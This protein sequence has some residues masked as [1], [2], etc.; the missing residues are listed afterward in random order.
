MMNDA[1][2]AAAGIELAAAG[3]AVLKETLR[4]N[5]IL[6]ANQEALVQVSPRFPGVI[7]EM[8]KRVGEQVESGETLA[9]VESN[10]SLTSYELKAPIAGTVIERQAALGEYVSEQ[11]P[12]FV[13]ADLTSVW[14]DFAITRRDLKRVKIGDTVVIDPEDGSGHIEGKISYI[15]P[16]GASDTQSALARAVVANDGKLLPGLFVTGNVVMAEKSVP[17]AIKLSAL[18][19][20][21]GRT[22]I[23]V[24]SGEKFEPREVELGRRD[25]ERV[26]VLFGII[27]GE[28]YAARNSFVVKA[29]IG[30]ASAAHEH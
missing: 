19:S 30:K 25:G 12:A 5:G 22:V 11:K 4:V 13:V 1:K 10:Q 8:R 16:V 23:F 7:R 3:P 2:I 17:L 26:E 29:E 27:E 21:D 9:R 6:Q 14:A 24:R 15:S 28:L 18:Q 20:L